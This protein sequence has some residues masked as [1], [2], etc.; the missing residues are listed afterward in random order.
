MSLK[1]EPSPEPLH[2]SA[3]WLRPTSVDDSEGLCRANLEHISQSW[4]DYGLGLSHFQYE[5]VLNHSGCS[6]PDRQGFVGRVAVRAE[7]APGT[8]TQSHISPSILVYEDK[9]ARFNRRTALAPGRLQCSLRFVRCRANMAHI[10]QTRPDS[11]LGF[12]VKVHKTF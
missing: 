9:H 3:K 11:G 8:P 10:S 6:L 2:I 1:Y 12:Q 5:R 4:S 7:V